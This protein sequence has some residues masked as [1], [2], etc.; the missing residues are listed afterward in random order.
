MGF[1]NNSGRF[2]IEQVDIGTYNV[3]LTREEQYEGVAKFTF[4]I[5]DNAQNLIN[6]K[7]IKVKMPKKKDTKKYIIF[8]GKK[9]KK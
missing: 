2:T 5:K 3:T 6:L 4:E 9:D 7:T 8:N 1:T